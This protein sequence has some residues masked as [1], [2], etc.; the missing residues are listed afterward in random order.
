MGKDLKILD[1]DVLGYQANSLMQTQ[2]REVVEIQAITLLKIAGIQ[3]DIV[4]I[5]ENAETHRLWIQTESARC[6]ER[7]RLNTEETKAVVAS[8]SSAM[9]QTLNLFG[10]IGGPDSINVS[11]KSKVGI[12]GKSCKITVKARRSNNIH[13]YSRG[14]AR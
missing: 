7:M 10:G 8:A 1:T 13:Y 12:F 4:R 2:D 9:H 11:V 14:P 5:E 6:L 3:R